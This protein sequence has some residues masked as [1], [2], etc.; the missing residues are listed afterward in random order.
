MTRPSLIWTLIIPILGM[1]M[2]TAFIVLVIAWYQ[3]QSILLNL[4]QTGAS[5]IASVV[6]SASNAMETN[7]PRLVN[8]IGAR[9]DVAMIIVTNK[10]NVLISTKRDW[11]G[12]HLREIPQAYLGVNISQLMYDAVN[13]RDSAHIGRDNRHFAYAFPLFLA[14]KDG[15]QEQGSVVVILDMH[16][17]EH[18]INSGVLLASIITFM[19]IVM[20]LLMTGWLL[21]RRVFAPLQR[22][23]H[24]LHHDAPDLMQRAGIIA[25]DEIGKVVKS[26]DRAQLSNRQQRQA[27]E[28][29]LREISTFLQ[30][31]QQHAIVSFA[32][33]TGRLIEVNNA[34]CEISGYTREEL[35]GD[36]H[37]MLTG[38][39][40]R[41]ETVSHIWAR[42][43][44]K[45]AVREHICC[46]R[47][48]GEVYWLDA[49][50]AP[51][52]GADGAIIKYISISS[53]ITER[54]RADAILS[55]AKERAEQ[56]NREL[57]VQTAQANDMAARAELSNQ[58]KSEFLANMSHEL[59]TPMN[60]I[61]GTTELLLGTEMNAQQAEYARATYRSGEALLTLLNDLLD[62]S[63]IEAGKLTLES[64]SFDPAQVVFDVIELFQV[65][66]SNKVELL[67]RMDPAL[68]VRALGDPGR[69]RQ[70]LTNLVG[71]AIKFTEQ[72]HVLIDVQ[73]RDGFVVLAVSDTGIGIPANRIKQLFSAFVQADA[74]T[75]R[76]FGGTGLGLAISRRIA[77]LMHGTLEVVSSEGKG[78]TFT[79]R[80]PLL[81]DNA[82]LSQPFVQS[83]ASDSL[84]N[85]RILVIDDNAMSG[86]IIV[87]QLTS[88]GAQAEC[89]TNPAL[90]I[91][92]IRENVTKLSPFT[93]ILID[94]H[95]PAMEGETLAATIKS[96]PII[97]EVTMLLL[98][99]MGQ[100]VDS[101][102]LAQNGF[103][104]YIP[105]PTRRETL[106]NVINDAKKN[107]RRGICEIATPHVAH[108]THQVSHLHMHA[109]SNNN[110]QPGGTTSP[111]RIL[112]A[113]DNVI[114]Q[115]I[116][117]G[118]LQKYGLEVT[119]VENGQ[120]AL[121]KV[122]QEPF[123]LIFMDCQMPIMDGYEAT[124]AIR[125]REVA[126]GLKR[127]PIV[128]MTANAMAQDR[129]RCLAAGMDDHLS[130][131]FKEAQLMASVQ[132]WLGNK[133][134]ESV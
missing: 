76:K 86:R 5:S 116:A 127:V 72:G 17:V 94:Q 120:D 65:R 16:Q 1:K 62:F 25:D 47:K 50:F 99:A 34:Y 11:I 4:A 39:L 54:K 113:E 91:P 122:K 56:L 36:E 74:S 42:L 14:T 27:L 111:K 31:L 70:I 83:P 46:Q 29:A 13:G 57:E 115:M 61:L 59:R 26:L 126:Q 32:D 77:E 108:A 84:S 82:Y 100:L 98:E 93:V 79:A 66:I 49:I 19:V 64:I 37:R 43:N 15:N 134:V 55:Q 24:E 123:D 40:D 106:A 44:N 87:E 45:Q 60:G 38:N 102:K 63:K 92:V 81:L 58:A 118:M 109:L 112:L 30:T 124:V 121:D 95:M 69:W 78:S 114:N 35:L 8:A 129:N 41:N 101:Q 90:A 128:A 22:I 33:A 75:S 89:L 133:R 117:Q 3:Q 85:E 51:F 68:P 80:L 23:E 12:H 73:W 53:D 71:N 125:S 20:S 88:L 18:Q 9:R 104:G 2:V 52:I 105:K 96:E 28:Q 48:N 130:K 119:V 10:D 103:A 97:K 21:H 132:Q 67:A 6:Q 131:P 107:Q 7:G 110:S